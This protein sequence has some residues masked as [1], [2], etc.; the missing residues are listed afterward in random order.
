MQR[1]PHPGV[2]Q[3]REGGGAAA[4]PERTAVRTVRGSC[5]T[6]RGTKHPEPSYRQPCCPGR[7]RLPGKPEEQLPGP[8]P[9]L[10]T[11]PEGPVPGTGRARQ[12]C[13]ARQGSGMACLL[14]P[15]PGQPWWGAGFVLLY[16]LPPPLGPQMHLGP[17][18]PWPCALSPPPWWPPQTPHITFPP[19]PGLCS[20]PPF[21]TPPPPHWA[22]SIHSSLC[23]DLLLV[24]Q[25]CSFH[26]LW[27]CPRS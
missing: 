1:A 7:R 19:R 8:T 15:G 25:S 9:L 2:T 11:L 21:Q 10:E 27:R 24:A 17:V 5:I 4:A 13:S 26:W 12:C 16:T 23:Y 22:S 18:L 20:L 14:S 6:V 3:H